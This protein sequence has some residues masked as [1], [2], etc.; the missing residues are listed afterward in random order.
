MVQT[1]PVIILVSPQMGENIGATARIMSNFGYEELRLVLPRDGW[2]NSK[3]EEMAAHGA[4]ILKDAR[5]FQTVDEAVADINF[6]VATTAHSRYMNKPMVTSARLVD[7]LHS[8]TGKTALMFG[9]ERSGLTNEEL[10]LADCIVSIPVSEKNPSLNLAQAVAVLAYEIIR[11]EKP[12]P[13]REPVS[14]APK[15][16]INYFFACLEEKLVA[17]GFLRHEKL[18]ATMR[19]NIR[20]LFLRAELTDQ[21][22][23]TLHGMINS[24]YKS[25]TTP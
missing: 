12:I 13:L 3:A 10:Q 19:K 23:R 8:S 6:L 5:I 17:S 2:P 21:D 25:S 1:L 9:R 4:Y 14:L 20:N 7:Q 15:H 24:L 18:R 22:L 11:V 16:E